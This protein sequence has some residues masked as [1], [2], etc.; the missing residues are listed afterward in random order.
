MVTPMTVI[1]VLLHIEVEPQTVYFELSLIGVLAAV[2]WIMVC[3]QP[4]VPPTEINTMAI[5]ISSY[6]ITR[7]GFTHLPPNIEPRKAA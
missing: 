1:P 2:V 7:L 4:H 5:L 6:Q 3:E